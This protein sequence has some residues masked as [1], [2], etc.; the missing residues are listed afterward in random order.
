MKSAQGCESGHPKYIVNGPMFPLEGD[1]R[2]ECLRVTR[3]LE[4]PLNESAIQKT[5]HP[6]HRHPLEKML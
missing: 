2:P 4:P 3:E 6:R 5:V 1:R